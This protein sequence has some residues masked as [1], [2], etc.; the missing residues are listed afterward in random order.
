MIVCAMILS[1]QSLRQIAQGGAALA[2]WTIFWYVITT[3]FSVAFSIVMSSQVWQP[4]YVVASDAAFDKANVESDLEDLEERK[5]HEV[6]VDLFNTFVPNNLAK[7][8][9]E[10]QLLAIIISSIIIGYLIRPEEEES[11]ILKVVNEINR[12]IAKII[13]VLIKLA[14]IGVFFL[15]LSNMFK[16]DVNDIGSNLGYLIA[17]TITS[18]LFHLFITLPLLF[19]AI[20]RRNPYTHWLRCSKAWVTAWGT[21]SSAGA[22]PIVI[23]SLRDQ[24]YPDTIISFAAPLGCMLNMD[25]AAI[26]FPSIAIFL[27]RTQG[28]SLNAGHYIMIL[29]LSTLAAIGSTPIPAAALVL[30]IMVATSAGIPITG[31]YAVVVAIDWLLD[32]FRTMVNTSGDLYAV[33]I[34]AKITGIKDP[35]DLSEEEVGQVRSNRVRSNEERV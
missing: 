32:R 9:A 23:R 15:I 11:P 29:L 13:G 21:A 2:R 14:P 5:P 34:L 35:E 31:M 1:V 25:G 18:M 30:S 20:T 27:A 17:G 8:F 26:Y 22:L 33:P 7:A 24:G 16:L 3:I 19:F 28:M 4:R 12:M 6:A 10:N